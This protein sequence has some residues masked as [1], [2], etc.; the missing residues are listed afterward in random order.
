MR[1]GSANAV[2]ELLQIL[3]DRVL[4][5]TPRSL[6]NPARR[7]VR[8]SNSESFANIVRVNGF[9]QCSDHVQLVPCIRTTE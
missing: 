8:L 5:C 6:P 4:R 1:Q 7:T 9:L 2:S 3:K